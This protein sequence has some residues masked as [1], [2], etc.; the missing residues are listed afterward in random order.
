MGGV[1]RIAVVRTPG[2]T[3]SP[4]T[5]EDIAENLDTIMDTSAALVAVVAV[6][7]PH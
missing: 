6:A 3:K 5:A 2:I 4:L 1:S 7:E